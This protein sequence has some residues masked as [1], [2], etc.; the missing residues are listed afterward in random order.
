[1]TEFNVEEGKFLKVQEELGLVIGYAIVSKVDGSE[2]FDLQGD[3]IPEQ[4]M[5]KAAMDFAQN[6]RTAGEMHR[7]T[8]EEKLEATATKRGEVVFVW[9]MT[10][11]IAKSFD[12]EPRITGLMI[13]MKPDDPAMLDKFRKGEYTGFS[14]GGK[15]LEAPQEVDA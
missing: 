11:E 1:M 12:I 2:Y 4:V 6:S 10:E 5:L 7:G 14:I 9:P 15:L 8:P 3:H 13:A